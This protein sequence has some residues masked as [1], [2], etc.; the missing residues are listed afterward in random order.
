MVDSVQRM[1]EQLAPGRPP[2][3]GFW[4]PPLS[5]EIDIQIDA[6]GVWYHEG[7]EDQAL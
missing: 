4:N 6:D 7:F 3:L 2:P 5:G 1:L